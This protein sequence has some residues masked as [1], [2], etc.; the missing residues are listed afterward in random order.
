M[1]D[2][3]TEH[4]LSPIELCT[5]LYGFAPRFTENFIKAELPEANRVYIVGAMAE[6]V[7]TILKHLTDDAIL[8]WQGTE[9]MLPGDIVIVYET[10][11][12]SRIGSIWRAVSPGFDD[13]FHYFPGKVFVGHPVKVPYLSFN[14]LQTDTVWGKKGLVKA[15]MQGVNGR[16]CSIEE[17]A[18]L[19]GM[20]TKKGFDISKFPTPPPYAQFYHE[21]LQVE[22][23]VEEKLLEPFLKRIGYFESDWTRQL[24][25]R[26]GRGI[27]YFPDYTLHASGTRGEER[28]DF[29][30]EA[31]FRIPTK[32]QLREDFGQAKSYALRLRTSGFGL[33]SMEGVW[34]SFEEDQFEFEKL[35]HLSWT[36]LERPDIFGDINIQ[37]RKLCKPKKASEQNLLF[38]CL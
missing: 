17:Y 30:W 25:L 27:R 32:K 34:I 4:H 24:P 37:L 23:D 1:Y 16:T 28:A 8:F 2:F 19:K 20:L 13:P 14:E 33:V 31:K 9:E 3:R 5:F 36:D 7:N 11:P 15:H 35:R 22:R 18:A 12:Y 26:M 38:A 10:A 21:D 29:I 6:D